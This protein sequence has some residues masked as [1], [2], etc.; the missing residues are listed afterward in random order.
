MQR[1][2]SQPQ[3]RHAL[4]F[5]AQCPN[6]SRFIDA[7]GRTSAAT[8]VSL[9]D[10]ATLA[11]DQLARVT[12]VPALV[13][14]DGT[15]MYGTKAFEWLKQYEGD[16]V[17]DGFSGENGALAFSDVSSTQAYASYS[18]AYSAFEPVAE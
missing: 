18:Q 6:C 8:D 2:S 14:S 16:T 9:V 7:L 1:R 4:L 15:T 5:S 17:L 11:P 10:V 3:P 12:A 13:L